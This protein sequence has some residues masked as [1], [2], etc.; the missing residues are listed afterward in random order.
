[1]RGANRLADQITAMT[2]NPGVHMEAGTIVT[3]G[4]HTAADGNNL[5]TV[6]WRGTNIQAAYLSSY[7]PIVGNTVL[8]LIAPPQV[9]ILAQLIGTPA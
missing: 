3:V 7:N 9:V 1:M 6:N 5:V 2:K 8:L 4:I